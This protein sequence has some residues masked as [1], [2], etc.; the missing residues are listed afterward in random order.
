MKKLLILMVAASVIFGPQILWAQV[1]LDGNSP[2][3]TQPEKPVPPEVINGGERLTSAEQQTVLDIA[4]ITVENIKSDLLLGDDPFQEAKKSRGLTSDLNGMSP[5]I[6]VKPN[7]PTQFKPS[8]PEEH[9]KESDRET[10]GFLR[11]EDSQ[12]LEREL[13][14]SL[15]EIFDS[16]KKRKNKTLKQDESGESKAPQFEDQFDY[17]L[18][19]AI[20]ELDTRLN[21]ILPGEAEE[22]EVFVLSAV[23][24]THDLRLMD[25]LINPPERLHP[26]LKWLLYLKHVTPEM[27]QYYQAALEQRDRIYMLAAKS[28]GKFKIRYQGRIMD[29]PIY[30]WPDQAEGRY[31]LVVVRSQVSA[32]GSESPNLPSLA[33]PPP[34]S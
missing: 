32:R 8:P 3:G 20:L 6:P 24:F 18:D 34:V 21:A 30:L 5:E 4:K 15:D 2:L 12:D 16:I 14:S 9:D 23:E 17:E 22:D 19:K 31:E 25:R 27:L 1:P 28:N 13:T 26:W 29:T 11:D 10:F 33:V 7:R